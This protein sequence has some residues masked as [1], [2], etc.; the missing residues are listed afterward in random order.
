MLGKLKEGEAKESA[1]RSL[2][3][4]LLR[5]AQSASAR[6]RSDL[7]RWRLTQ[8]GRLRKEDESN[9]QTLRIFQEADDFEKELNQN[10]LQELGV[11]TD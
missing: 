11:S 9:K 7:A 10:S 2:A 5:A 8:L 6:S 1:R 4:Q 3:Q